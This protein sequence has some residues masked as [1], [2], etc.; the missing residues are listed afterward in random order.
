MSRQIPLFG[1]VIVMVIFFIAFALST[2]VESPLLKFGIPLVAI[3][4]I[5]SAFKGLSY[6]KKIVADIIE[7]GHVDEYVAHHGVGNQK[8]FKA[9]I[10]QLR[11][12]GYTINQGIERRLWEEIKK[13]TG[14]QVYQT[15]V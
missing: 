5:L 4:F 13:K 3:I 2:A 8:T 1:L 6:E 15:S 9:F 14:Y 12:E 10:E 11:N 7:A